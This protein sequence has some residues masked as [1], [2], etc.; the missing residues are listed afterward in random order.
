MKSYFLKKFSVREFG[1]NK[2]LSVLKDESEIIAV[3]DI[4]DMQVDAENND[5]QT[6]GTLT[7]VQVVAA[8]QVDS[9]K[10]CLVC[11]VR[12]EPCTPPLGQCSRCFMM[13]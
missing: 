8:P 10:S 11:K 13:Q 2:Y 1:F 9:Y 7:Q 5:E 4:G 12:V 3:D 6:G